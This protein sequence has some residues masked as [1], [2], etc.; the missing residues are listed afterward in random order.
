M[1]ARWLWMTSGG[2]LRLL[3]LEVRMTDIKIESM[4]TITGAE[5]VRLMD[6]NAKLREI[7]EETAPHRLREVYND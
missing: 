2:A 1:L 3:L 4:V 5:Y 6:E 7:V